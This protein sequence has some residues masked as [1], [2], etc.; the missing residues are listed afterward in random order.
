MKNLNVLFSKLLI[1]VLFASTVSCNKNTGKESDKSGTFYSI[2]FDEIIKNQR[3]VNLSEIA[4]DVDIIQLENIPEAML[5]DIED[6]ALTND[7][8]FVKFWQHPILQFSHNGKF[9]RNIGKK[10]N[11]PG[12]YTTCMKMS[13]DE[14]REKI[15]VQT[16]TQGMMVFNF[17]GEYLKTI[18]FPA[19]ESFFDF[20]IGGRDSTLIKYF[21][22]FWGNEPFVFIEYNEQGDTLQGIPNYIFFNE[23]ADPFQML[24]ALDRNYSYR[25]NN[26]LH[27]KGCYNDTVYTYDANNKFVP[28]YAIDLGKYKLPDDLIYERKWTRPMPDDLIWTGVHETSDYVFMPYGY[29]FNLN[30]PETEKKEKGLALYN[31]KTKQGIAINETEKGGLNDDLAGGPD[32]RPITTNDY[33]ALMRISA[34]DLK[35]YLDSEPFKNKEVKF[36]EK[37]EQLNE[38]RKALKE[39]DN[40][41]V[42]LVKLKE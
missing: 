33:T 2:P 9:I 42:M 6:I 22:P 3:E 10:G 34:M 29:H 12:E 41:F 32:F 19:L 8:I 17:D 4:T 15:Y 27:L 16:Q 40:D 14:K 11:G 36:P 38:L 23:Q 39:E 37:K 1:V 5:G 30:K 24:Y 21:E 18:Q 31:K 26:K 25:F 28:K 35:Q 7:Y 20:W 13:I